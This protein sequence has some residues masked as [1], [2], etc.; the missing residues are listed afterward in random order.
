M[1]VSSLL[2]GADSAVSD[3]ECWCD[4]IGG[5]E[6]QPRGNIHVDIDITL[7]ASWQQP[8]SQVLLSGLPYIL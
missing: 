3:T 2:V 7:P 1:N 5:K 8:E 4:A 6:T